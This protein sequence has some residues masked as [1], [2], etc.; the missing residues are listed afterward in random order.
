MSDSTIPQHV[1]IICDGNRRWA[2]EHKLEVFLGHR[3][4]VDA[5]FE[6][7]VDHAHAKG[8]K[9]ITFWI[10][11][12][13]NWQ[14]D[15]KEVDYLLELFK[16]V[17]DSFVP[18]FHE[19]NIRVTA[20]GDISKFDEPIQSRI[21]KGIELT[22]DN[23][24]ITVTFAMNYGGRDELLRAVNTLMLEKNSQSEAHDKTKITKEDI[25]RVL[26]TAHIPDP[27]F[28]IRTSG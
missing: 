14:R 2:R 17:F 22:K 16:E 19:K 1:A 26:D 28:I 23:T 21:K 3:R 24:G 5:V 8:I 10:F 9:Y 4:A 12:T 11:S 25:E 7:L 27:D 13:E 20:I 18:R 6:P 15:K